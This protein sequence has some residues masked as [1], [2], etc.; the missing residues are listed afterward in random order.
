MAVNRDMRTGDSQD[1]IRTRSG[2]ALLQIKQAIFSF[3]PFIEAP[4]PWVLMFN[5][6]FSIPNETNSLMPGTKRDIDSIYLEL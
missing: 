3:H 6:A 1:R 5:T 4:N 2:T